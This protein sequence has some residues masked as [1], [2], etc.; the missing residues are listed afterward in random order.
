MTKFPI[1][2]KIVFPKEY[3]PWIP[4][5][6]GRAD[7]AYSIEEVMMLL[8][9]CSQVNLL[10]YCCMSLKGLLTLLG[11]KITKENV[12]H[13]AN[14]VNRL[15]HR[16]IKT[17][18]VKLK[19]DTEC[20]PSK[21]D[22]LLY[23]CLEGSWHEAKSHFIDISI[24][25]FEKIRKCAIKHKKACW[26][27]LLLFMSLKS[28]FYAFEIDGKKCYAG[29]I[30]KNTLS[31]R[32]EVSQPTIDSLISILMKEE[33]I[34]TLSGKQYGVSNVYCLFGDEAALPI[35]MKHQL[36]YM[37]INPVERPTRLL[38]KRLEGIC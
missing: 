26:V 8:C 5:E 13:Y 12:A 22:T 37:N 9:I 29:V 33:I 20:D 11:I 25:E 21:P 36:D 34:G 6:K 1:N 10:G 38:N 19:S 17:D 27:L 23:I 28:C 16:G 3:W 7:K 2:L 30:A 35:A 15:V 18:Y 4:P 31:K 32:C 24:A 14:I